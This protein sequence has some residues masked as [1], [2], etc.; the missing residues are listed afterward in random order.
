MKM[1]TVAVVIR[2]K[3]I[4]FAAVLLQI[5]LFRSLLNFLTGQYCKS[6]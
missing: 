4:S 3:E 5:C 2:I 6:R 1:K